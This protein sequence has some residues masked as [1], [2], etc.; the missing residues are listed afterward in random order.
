M[1]ELKGYA[2]TAATLKRLFSSSKPAILPSSRAMSPDTCSIA[3]FSI[4]A[5]A[6]ASGIAPPEPLLEGVKS[7]A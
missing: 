4:A 2:P 6:F 5:T 3:F 1:G 7:T